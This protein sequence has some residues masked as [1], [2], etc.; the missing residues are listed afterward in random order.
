[1]KSY[2]LENLELFEK[3]KAISNIKRFK[4]VEMTQKDELNIKELSSQLN[5]AYTK[6]VD[7]VRLLGKLHL[8]RKNKEGKETKITSI[9][10]IHKNSLEFPIFSTNQNKD[11]FG[12]YVN[13][14]NEKLAISE[15][16]KK[17]KNI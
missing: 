5:L 14:A 13:Q 17:K 7:Y 8:I 15:K 1:M 3:V 2:N 10:K 12:K 6:T 9:V 4:I 11:A 16:L